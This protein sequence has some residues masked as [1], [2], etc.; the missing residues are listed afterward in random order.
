M[1][2]ADSKPAVPEFYCGDN[3]QIDDSVGYLIRRIALN[4]GQAVDRDLA[5][6]GLSDAQ[7]KPLFM[8]AQGRAST[9]AELAHECSSDP[10]SM[11][12]LLDRLEAKDLLHRVRSSQDR[13]VVHLE[14]TPAGREAVVE[15]PFVLAA[16][17][18]A[19][20]AGFSEQE[21]LT[22]K[23]LLRRML[24]TAEALRDTAC[25]SEASRKAAS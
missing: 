7:W 18:N 3:Y 22:L 21:W 20:L 8:L 17:V 24:D 9:V 23:A 2:T 5:I 13:R 1:S 12:R 10:A 14:I 15:V 11:T 6:H 19:H 25:A 4:L 16:V